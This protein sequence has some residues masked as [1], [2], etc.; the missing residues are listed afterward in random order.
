MALPSS[1]DEI[2]DTDNDELTEG[3]HF[4]LLSDRLDS[5]HSVLIDPPQDKK[6]LD[7]LVNVR[8]FYFSARDSG[9][10][11]MP[12]AIIAEYVNKNVIKKD[13][14]ARYTHD[15]YRSKGEIPPLGEFLDGAVCREQNLITHLALAQCGIPSEYVKGSVRDSQ[16]SGMHAWVEVPITGEVI[17]AVIGKAMPKD[18]YYKKFK[19]DLFSLGS[20]APTVYA[21]PH[22]E[23]WGWAI[24]KSNFEFREQ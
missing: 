6:L 15:K 3:I 19:V 11:R 8:R 16:G 12:T 7:F 23:I 5:A 13:Y 4:D 17:D 14:E 1:V 24:S 20:K 21:R 10:L 2:V 9:D 22:H 18:E